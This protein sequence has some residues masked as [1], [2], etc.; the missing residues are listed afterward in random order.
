MT[1]FYN[2]F[3]FQNC[4]NNRELSFSPVLI[5]SWPAFVAPWSSRFFP[6]VCKQTIFRV[7]TNFNLSKSNKLSLKDFHA[8][9]NLKVCAYY[10]KQKNSFQVLEVQSWHYFNLHFLIIFPLSSCGNLNIFYFVHLLI[11]HISA[12]YY[13]FKLF[14]DINNI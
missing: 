10:L 14:A 1:L 13:S 5:I 12:I 2:I 6:W 8:Y 11:W 4:S 7:I 9:E 3:V